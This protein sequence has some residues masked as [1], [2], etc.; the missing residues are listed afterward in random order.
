MSLLGNLGS[1][2][3][4]DFCVKGRNQHQAVV[5]MFFYIGNYRLQPD[6]TFVVERNATITDQSCT[7]QEIIDHY[8]FKNI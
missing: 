5:Y 6:G 3:I 7:V 2:V 4:A 1:F 8:W